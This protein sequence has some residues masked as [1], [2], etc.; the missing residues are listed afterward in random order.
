MHNKEIEF[1]EIFPW[2]KN[3]ETGIELIDEQH[4]ELIN[5][6]NR[7]AAHLANLSSAPAL[8]E[9]FDELADYADYHFKSEEGIWS[10]YFKDDDWFINHEK[11]HGSFIHEVIELKNNKE[12]KPYDDVIY[13]IV[14][15][16]SKWLAYH[17]LDTDK[18]MAKTVLDIKSGTTLKD[19]KKQAEIDMSGSMHSHIETVLSMYGSISTRTLDLMREKALRI[20]AEKALQI[21][22]ERWKFILDSGTDNIWDWDIQSDQ[23]V[24]SKEDDSILDIINSKIEENNKEFSIHPSDIK[25]VKIDFKEHLDGKTEFF[26]N[27]HR[28]LK[29][30]GSWSWILSQGKV[31]GR[32]IQGNPLHM[33]GTNTDI[34]ERE[35]GSLIYKNS[36]QSMFV[37]DTNNNI[38]SI[39]PAFSTVTG[40]HENDIIGK[41]PKILASGKHNKKF[42]TDMWDKLINK[43]YWHGE[44][45]NKRK[46]GEIYVQDLKINTVKNSNGQIDH[47]VALF[48]DISDKKRL[49]EI[50]IKQSNTDSLTNLENRR[51]F[52]IHLEQEIK[53]SSRTKLPFAVLFIDL[54]HFKNV[55]DSLGHDMGDILL[56]N[57]AKRIKSELRDS[58][59]LARLGGDEFTII[60][61]D[62][63]EGLRVD[64]IAQ[65]IINKLSLPFILN[66]DKIYISASIGITIYP[67][68]ATKGSA[69]LTNAD[70]AMYQ[71][72][73][74]GRSRFHYFT[75]S[76]QEIAQ[77]RKN[78]IRDMHTALDLK[79]FQMYYQPIV[80]LKTNEILKAEALIRWNVD[81]NNVVLPDD[82]IPLAEQ[83]GYIVEIGNWVYKESI[84]Q[85]QEWIN[86]YNIDFKV[87]INKSPVQFRNTKNLDN[88]IEHLKSNNLNGKN[89]VIEI[90]ENLLMENQ[91][92][93]TNKLSRFR[94]EGIE[95]SLDD[96]GTGYSS[97]S[98]LKKLDIDYLKID[99]SFIKNL[100]PDS[101]DIVLCEAIIAMA[102][103]LDIKVVA[104]GIETKEQKDLLSKM[105]CHYGQGFYFSKPVPADVFEELFLN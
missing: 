88:W 34:T 68:D 26:N 79:Q 85:I 64:Y 1:F 105:G 41:N 62:I 35:L 90:T 2:D 49:D 17:I 37:S 97:L 72:K 67:T 78:L 76:M 42:Y 63:T 91:E 70:Q 23:L 8:D 102:L 25:Q 81:D 104:E 84:R 28:I 50:I 103:K 9:I 99:K 24:S 14:I 86:K 65:N 10:R 75:A 31:V 98:Y 93:I 6:L 19:A 32:D 74:T 45:I 59:I 4:K 5:I 80:D 16:L 77:K 56:I 48:S 87:S 71:A 27:K 92:I 20:Q 54:D 33:V 101:S 12:N 13:D 89:L 7:L 95:I 40:Y 44:V 57:A 46:N 21:S 83:S 94:N 96:F 52:K 11:T 39:N 29:N 38:I 51:M 43:N 82:F 30:D 15:F 58:D 36:S 22:E 100:K 73:K 47:Y 66:D 53:R 69:L 60:L 61:P 55:N 3:F 18:R